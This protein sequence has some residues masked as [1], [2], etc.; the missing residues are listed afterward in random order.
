[1]GA[2]LLNE[3]RTQRDAGKIQFTDSELG[4][5]FMQY[6]A[7]TNLNNDTVLEEIMPLLSEAL[8]RGA[9]II[10]ETAGT[11][12]GD[13]FRRFLQKYLGFNFVQMHL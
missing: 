2:A 3:L 5:R 7:D 9:V 11:K 1:M 8:T 13:V 4:N 10:N 6:M 12:I